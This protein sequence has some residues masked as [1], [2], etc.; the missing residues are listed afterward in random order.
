MIE[1][2]KELPSQD[3]Y[4]QKIE[5]MLAKVVKG[6]VKS[7]E[8]VP[9]PVVAAPV[10]PPEPTTYQKIKELGIQKGLEKLFSMEES[11]DIPHYISEEESDQIVGTNLFRV[12]PPSSFPD[13]D[14][15]WNRVSPIL[16]RIGKVVAYTGEGAGSLDMQVISEKGEEETLRIQLVRDSDSGDRPTLTFEYVDRDDLTPEEVF[17][18]VQRVGLRPDRVA[19]RDLRGVIVLD[20]LD[21]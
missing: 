2:K 17:K 6:E 10:I 3:A 13:A 5:S 14:K 18:F 21:R 9:E 4:K 16:K 12:K 20:V 1:E 19:A 8:P 15:Y 7:P 11:V